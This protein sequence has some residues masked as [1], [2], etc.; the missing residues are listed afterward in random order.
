MRAAWP[1]VA[2]AEVASFLNGGT[3][4]R[5]KPEYF[6]GEIPWITGADIP[7]GSTVVHGGRSHI[8]QEA[9]AK[10]ATNLVAAG[11]VLLV[12]RTGVGKAAIAGVDLAYSQ[13]ITAIVHDES[14]IDRNYLV[15]CLL[16]QAPHFKALAQGA[17]IKGVTRKVV[18]E[19]AIPLPPIGEQRRIAA[20]LD[21]ADALRDKRRQA[22]AK[23]DTLT[24][25]MFID[26][27]GDPAVNP[28]GWREVP[29]ADVADGADGIKCGPFGTQLAQ[30]DYTHSG[31]PLWGI[32]H[33]NRNFGIDTHE[34][35]TVDKAHALGA[36][37]IRPGDIVMTRKGTVGNCAVYPDDKP[38]GVMHSDLLRLRVG[39]NTDPVFL[40]T[41]LTHSRSVAE[42]I[43]AMSGGAIMAGINVTK[44]KDLKVLAPP[45]A[46]QVEFATRAAKAAA[47]I[48]NAT[49]HLGTLGSLFASLQQRAFRGE[50]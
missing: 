25:A 30:A 45:L 31:V 21:E 20:V 3:P 5:S 50:L 28:L 13:D 27:F 29:V 24:L 43:R 37:S 35:L 22:L 19:A 36:F 34:F 10:S 33:V 26:M 8:T 41:Q 9:V 7:E 40:T 48:A 18:E 39:K 6:D 2:L 46:A 11:T 12:T 14:R 47:A 23:L 1:E 15:R 4:S 32:P 42:Q 17:T 49:T 16:Y 38:D 44:L